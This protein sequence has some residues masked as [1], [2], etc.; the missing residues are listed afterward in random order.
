VTPSRVADR[1]EDGLL[2]LR[3]FLLIHSATGTR[4]LRMLVTDGEKAV[5]DWM[6]AIG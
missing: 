4:G 5:A 2:F 1:G 6:E 3:R